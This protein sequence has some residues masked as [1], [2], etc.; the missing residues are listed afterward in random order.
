M[1]LLKAVKDYIS[2][3]EK[4]TVVEGGNPG[5]TKGG[6]GDILAGLSAS[7]YAR[8]EAFVSCILASYLLKKTAD[9]L[10]LQGGYWYNIDDIISAI[11]A[12]TADLLLK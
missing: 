5:L 9:K 2:D 10:F 1:V 3:G 4:T 7:L 8:N 6:T 11:P 12:I